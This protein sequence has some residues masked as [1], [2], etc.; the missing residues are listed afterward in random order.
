MSP[1]SAAMVWLSTLAIPVAVIV[2]AAS[3]HALVA[4]LA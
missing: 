4:T 1:A 2:P 3:Y